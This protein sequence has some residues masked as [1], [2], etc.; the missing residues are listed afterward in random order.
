MTIQ[1]IT[2]KECII[3]Y[4]LIVFDDKHDETVRSLM[5]KTF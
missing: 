2:F 4:E 3:E 1:K 5:Q